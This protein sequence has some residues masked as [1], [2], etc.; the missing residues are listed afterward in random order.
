MT[1]LADFENILILSLRDEANLTQ[2]IIAQQADSL[3]QA[4][5]LDIPDKEALIKRVESKLVITMTEGISLVDQDDDHDDEWYKKQ[6]IDWD[7]WKD[8]ERQLIANKWSPKVVNTLGDVTDKILGLLKNPTEP[9]DWDRRGLVIGHVQSGKTANY[10][11][12]VSKAADAGYKFIIV[13]AGLHNNLRKQTQI[14]ID[15]GFIGRDSTPNQRKKEVGVGI[16]SRNRKFPITL[17]TTDNDFTKQMADALGAELHGFSQPVVV[18]IKKNVNTL[19]SLHNWL[20]EQNLRGDADKIAGVPMLMI[21]DEA[22][23]ASIN[24]KRDDLDPTRTNQKIRQIL[25][26]FRKSCYVGY[27]A[28]P[29]A[30]IFINP[31]T[32]DEMLEDDLFPKDF[33]YC[34][35]APTNYFGPQKVFLDEESSNKILSTINDAEDYIPMLHKKDWEVA[36]LPPSMTQAINDFVIGKAIRILREQENKH[37]S[38]MINASRFVDVQRQIKENV[39][40]YIKTIKDAIQFNYALPED[41]ALKNAH[42]ADLKKTYDDK[43]ASADHP[44]SEVQR[45]LFQSVEPI[46]TYLIN[47]SSDD[48]LDYKHYEDAGESLTVIAVGGLSLSRGLTLEGLIVSYMYRSTKMYDTLMQMGR[49]FGYR[50][51]FEDICKIWLP[52][53]SQGWYGH[54]AEAIEELRQQIKQMRRDKLTP[55]EFGLFVRKHPDAPL[56]ITARN[57]MLDAEE[58]T[59][60]QSLS[61]KLEETVVVPSDQDINESNLK[62]VGTMFNKLRTEEPDKIS[63]I[64]GAYFCRDVRWKYI[65]ETLVNFKFHKNL[66]IKKQIILKYF[67]MIAEIY[68]EV[69]IAFISLKNP[70][71]N[72]DSID[73]NGWKFYCQTRSVGTLNGAVKKPAGQSGYHIT[74]RRR[75]GSVGAESVGL[76]DEQKNQ[77]KTESGSDKIISD[78]HYRK[79]RKKPLLMFHLLKLIH[80]DKDTHDVKELLNFIPA[81]GIS[82]PDGNYTKSVKVAVNK[83]WLQQD[84]FDNFDNPE[85]EEEEHE[86]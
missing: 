60:D 85:E 56:L 24:T 28:T 76:S 47:S 14:R 34:L 27:T 17:T 74:N 9:P 78:I 40:F 73:M 69:D 66:T 62:F 64:G 19:K 12:L 86:T 65:E 58:M 39:S 22:D 36:D 82:F 23:N 16:N 30:N 53:E 4:L 68:P 75:V 43:F 38:M 3:A 61:G 1:N 54:I 48:T 13:I 37:C 18:V 79:V 25:R 49:W 63:D 81:I 77:A 72:A 11:G 10:I 26:L 6:N 35:D 29:F 8:Y 67:Q 42:V 70:K 5:G 55:K 59:F 20:R 41:Q 31:E 15:E 84:F 51:S 45:V 33:I 80:K 7:Y 21:D 44:W 52:D 50:D 32:S 46:K 57:K 71:P 2:D 83:P